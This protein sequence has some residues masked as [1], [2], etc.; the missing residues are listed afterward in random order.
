MFARLLLV[1]VVV[2]GCAGRRGEILS[3]VPPQP[4]LDATHVIYLHG[5]IVEE[6][7]ARPTDERFGVYEYQQILDVFAATG[8]TVIAE[9]RPQGTDFMRFGA[10][11]AEQ[12]R[13]LLAA[14]VPPERIAVVG[15]SKGGGIAIIAAAL[16]ADPRIRFVFLG[17]CG[18]WL[19]DRSDVNV[20]GRILSVYEASDEL[21]T[22]CQPLFTRATAPGEHREVVIQTGAGHGAFFRPRAEWITPTF[23]WLEL[24]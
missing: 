22:S 20:G 9:Q 17:A 21:G 18:D 14:G 19:N 3:R 6:K 11:V 1:V 16:L 12:V 2:A 15:F 8:A 10:H 23:E 13:A 24:R 4:R 7:G 5:R